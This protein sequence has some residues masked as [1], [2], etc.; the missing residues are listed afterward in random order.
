MGCRL[1][2]QL[3]L[4]HLFPS[5]PLLLLLAHP[6]VR[7]LLRHLLRAPC[8]V[9]P[10]RQMTSFSLRFWFSHCSRPSLL[11]LLAPQPVLW[12]PTLAPLTTWSP[13]G[14]PSFHTSPCKASASAW[15]TIPLLQSWAGAR[16]LSLSTANVF[17]SAM[18]SMSLA[19]GSPFIVSGHIFASRGVVSWGATRL[20]CTCT[21]Q[22]WS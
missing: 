1:T 4:T 13:T 16:L 18:S 12:L 10:S 14:A 17:L 22:A 21:S 2:Q 3:N 9:S 7:S 19:S 15:V 8:V 6:A 5:T 11:L 20:A